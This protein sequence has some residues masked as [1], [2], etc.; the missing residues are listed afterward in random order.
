MA[1]FVA[2]AGSRGGQILPARLCRGGRS[3]HNNLMPPSDPLLENSTA[4]FTL[5]GEFRDSDQE[6]RFRAG[7]LEEARDLMQACCACLCAVFL[8]LLVRD[9]VVWDGD[10]RFFVAAGLRIFG[11]IACGAFFWVVD[12]ARDTE[13]IFLATTIGELLVSLIASAVWVLERP[14]GLYPALT[15]CVCVFA[16]YMVAPNTIRA[17]LFNAMFITL[18]YAAIAIMVLRT[19]WSDLYNTLVLLLGCNVLG[20]IGMR[21]L[22]MTR[23][24]VWLALQATAETSAALVA[25]RAETRDREHYQAAALD[26]LP[27]G[28]V[29]V[30]AERRVHTMNRRAAE[31]LALPPQMTKPGVGHQELLKV[32]AARRDFGALS[33]EEYTAELRRLLDGAEVTVARN[34]RSGRV[35]EFTVGRLPGNSVAVAIA[36]VSDRHALLRRLRHAVEV[37]G[38]GFAIYDA[39]DRIAICSSHFAAL[40]GLSADE[41]VGRHFDE[42]MALGHERGIFDP[43]EQRLEFGATEPRRSDRRRYPERQIEIRTRAGE[44]YIVDERLTPYGDLVVVR[45]NITARRLIEDELRAAKDEAERMLA[46]LKNTQASLVLA[47]KMASLGSLVAGMSHEISTPLGIGVSAASH[48]S[49]EIDALTQRFQDGELTRRD[50]EDF[51]E[52]AREAVRIMQGNLG[53]AARLM[54]AFKQVAADQTD[55]VPRRFDLAGY[56]RDIL[57]SLAPEL[58]RTPHQVEIDCPEGIEVLHRP[59]AMGQIVTNLVL[60]A[61]QHGFEERA[62]GT[63]R[64]NVS[65]LEGG[66][67]IRLD[68]ADNGR[69]IPVADR[70]QIFDPFFTTRRGSGGTGLGLHIV[71]TLVT[72][73]LGGTISVESAPGAGTQ[74]RV[75]FPL[76]APQTG[77]QSV[78]SAA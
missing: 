33:V 56:L 42:L 71:Y 60:N 14:L 69:G 4:R 58:R 75:E 38:D 23:R 1:L 47:E 15:T 62:P 32:F 22:K 27:L 46:E 68:F 5:G 29:L 16:Y 66:E 39:D 61:L 65:L 73:A 41:A 37:A 7:L 2:A 19:P 9:Y 64:I 74:F 77:T 18:S 21:K 36:D 24:R 67:R 20:Y 49:E 44:W 8:L 28:V 76:T 10:D 59:G 25:A 53:R 6:A 72:Q 48:L 78:P 26:A 12:T 34:I 3:A 55:D 63:I 31:L 70:P 35:L 40:Y 43:D 45:T 52:A 13:R 30:D 11:L 57:L 51:L 50:L 17:A 54:R